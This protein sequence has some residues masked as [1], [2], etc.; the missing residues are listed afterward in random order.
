MSFCVFDCDI[1]EFQAP[2]STPAIILTET[3]LLKPHC[4]CVQYC[5]LSNWTKSRHYITLKYQQA[6]LKNPVHSGLTL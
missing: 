6:C 2:S 1:H 3:A 5:V 4:V